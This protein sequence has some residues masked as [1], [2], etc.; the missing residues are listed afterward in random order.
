M[1][2]TRHEATRE[3]PIPARNSPVTD[4]RI[5]ILLVDD[6]PA[7]LDTLREYL[8][9][10]GNRYVVET[11]SQGRDALWM[12]ARAR[13]HVVILDVEMPGMGGVQVL[14]SLRASDPTLPVI[15]L[16]ANT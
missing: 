13:P 11:A 4:E 12:V 7:L 3:P 10:L 9:T 5:R 2:I 6:D 14:T 8:E 16:T 15:M 1:F